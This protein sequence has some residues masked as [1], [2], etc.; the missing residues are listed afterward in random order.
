VGSLQRPRLDVARVIHIQQNSPTS[1]P[2]SNPQLHRSAVLELFHSDA[3]R[4]KE[5]S[6]TSALPWLI[7][8]SFADLRT[9]CWC[10]CMRVWKAERKRRTFSQLY[11]K[12]RS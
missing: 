8:D 1:R 9:R 2:Q 11:M 12:H 6:L 3:P 5:T 10:Y 4:S 7:W